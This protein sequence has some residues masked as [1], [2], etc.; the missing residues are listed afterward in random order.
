MEAINLEYPFYYLVA[1]EPEFPYRKTKLQS[2]H[3]LP[4]ECGKAAGFVMFT[5]YCNENLYINLMGTITSECT[6]SRPWLKR[7]RYFIV[8][9]DV[10]CSGEAAY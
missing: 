3:T 5:Y 4:P 2:T 6:E 10:I 1:A 7:R 8:H 9:S